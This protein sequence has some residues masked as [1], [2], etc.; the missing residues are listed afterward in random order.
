VSDSQRAAAGAGEVLAQEHKLRRDLGFWGLTAIGF[1]NIVGSGWLFAAMYAAQTAGPASILAWIGAGLLCALVALVM[2]E[3]GVSR[4]EG[5][6]TVRWPLFAS[7]R[8]VGTLIGWSTL[9]SVGGTAAEISA[10]MQYAGHYLP[11]VYA[12]GRITGT[13]LGVAVGLTVLLTALNWFAVRVFA[14][15]N[16]LVS[17]FKVVVPVLTVVAL[18]A[19]GFQ[20][21]RMS[22]PALGGFAPYG[23]AAVLSALASGGIV[24]S[25]NGFQAPL[26]F[27]GEARNPRRTVAWSVLAGIGFA[28][29]IYL[30]LQIAFL[31]SVPERLLGHGWRG[32]SF[33][34]PFG[35]LAL[36]LNLQWLS[37]LL[38]F[39]AVVS[40]GG[41]AYVGVA[42]DA[43]HTYALA[44]NGTL[45]RAVMRVSDRSGIPH[46]AL[47]LNFVVIILFLLPFGGW[48]QI[49][50]VM[51]DLYLLI[52]SASAV[53]VAVLRG[54]SDGGLLGWVPG[55]TWIAPVSFVV[56]SEFV[57]WSGWHDLRLALPM[58]LI[59]LLL[60]AFLR[61][62]NRERGERGGRG[63]GRSDWAAVGAEFLRG[64]W[65]VVYLLLLTLLSWLG[66]FKGSDRLPAPYDSITVAVVSAAL[67]AWAV[68]SGRGLP[69]EEAE[70][71]GPSAE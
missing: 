19:S 61:P 4:P 51:G 25:L 20:S 36:I 43:R 70:A 67:F 71:L 2:V 58:V 64:S 57:Y 28:L 23:Y 41:S 49:V 27:S 3:L 18:L 63:G 15:F 13:G 59:G 17:A 55:L 44:K 42:I 46:R 7:G 56:A 12:D 26:D 54:R 40:P 45:P 65:L 69:A 47:L 37:S 22:A 34:S 14:R 9:L 48:Q 33:D 1:S 11:G 31:F 39:D 21:G 32:V 6:G 16:N 66:S 29:L 52:Y 30:A 68:R 38:Y 24:Y 35:Q 5:G 62:E 8:L 10:I 50:S 53:A 60:F